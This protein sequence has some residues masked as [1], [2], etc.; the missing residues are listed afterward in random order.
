MSPA[1]PAFDY[2]WA[3]FAFCFAG[4]MTPGPNNLMLMASGVNYGFARTLP[5]IAG[6]ILGYSFL[7]LM[8]GLG[9]ATLFAAYPP[10]WHALRFAGT[11]YLL[12]LAW[13]VANAGP[14]KDGEGGRPFN[15]LQAAAFQWV[16]VKGVLLAL[17]A[18]AAFT[19][20]DAFAGTLAVLIAVSTAVSI[21]S[22]VTWTLFGSALRPWLSDPRR[23]RPFNIGMA[24]LLT[25]S[26]W[27]ML[28]P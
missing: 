18:V 23:A 14:V 22:A 20:P 2:A 26:L 11:L 4:A 16:N 17:T 13:K 19:R 21:F 5:H 10:A 15:F 6:V 28:A 1:Q 9:V 7:M 8:A 24:L 27:P 25:A 3:A 12:W